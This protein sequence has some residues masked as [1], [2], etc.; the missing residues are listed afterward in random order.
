MGGYVWENFG[1]E[2]GPLQN[3]SLQKGGG[4]GGLVFFGFG[5]TCHVRVD[6][7]GKE[8]HVTVM[9]SVCHPCVS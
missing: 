2:G 6:L 8:A 5:W 7:G 4:G 3:P 1:G 9:E